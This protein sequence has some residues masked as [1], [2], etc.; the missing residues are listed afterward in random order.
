[1]WPK[2]I[3]QLIEL[4]PHVTRLVPVAE[5]YLR[6]QGEGKET[7]Q[8]AMEQMASGLRG[9]LQTIAAA[10]AGMDQRLSEQSETL[11][12]IA[13]EV[14]AAR[15]A[16]EAVEA[17]LSRIEAQISRL[18]IVGVIGAVLMVIATAGVVLIAVRMH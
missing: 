6:S 8:Q 10:Q 11:A 1:M 18:W 3:A 2:A 4:A 7:S 9:E 15:L 5:R 13:A 14:R 12:K 16:S 17:R